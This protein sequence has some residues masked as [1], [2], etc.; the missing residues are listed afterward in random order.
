MLLK[1]CPVKIYQ[2]ILF[3]SAL[4]VTL[5]APFSCR[6]EIDS[7]VTRSGSHFYADSQPFYYTGTNNFYLS[8]FAGDESYRPMVD[9]VLSSAKS[10]GLSVIRT[11]AFNDGGANRDGYPVS[12]AYQTA[13]G[14]YNENAFKGLDYVLYK[15]ESY[16][17]RVLPT[18]V[19]NWDDY[20]G[21][22]WYN[23]FSPSAASHDDFYTDP[24]TRQW[25]K[26][27]VT[28]V[29]NRTN[30]YNGR[31]YKDDPTIMA[32]EL[33]NEAR[34][35]SDPT[36]AKLRNWLDEM[37]S[38]VKANDANHLVTTG[39]EGF[40]KDRGSQWYQNGSTGGDFVGDHNLANIDFA[41]LH[42]YSDFWNWDME[43]ALA[44]IEQHISDADILNKPLIFEEFGKQLP[45]DVRD[46]WY[47]AY[48]TAVYEAAARGSSMAGSNFWMLEADASG[49]ND[50]FGVSYPADA[51]TIGIIMSNAEAMNGLV[52]EPP[53][54][55]LFLASLLSLCYNLRR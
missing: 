21:M 16:G 30:T 14:V 27:Y 35:E 10:M 52:P 25:Y 47:R 42:V 38:Y 51:S 15:A 50:G 8:Y 32:W 11:W 17:I 3:Y 28:T 44:W 48:L 39:V 7:F 9:Q 4:I 33:A 24:A 46:T 19:N 5:I 41:T 18:L 20:G 55:F 6:A 26:D 1:K 31:V 53:T 2:S 40:Y 54:V 45:A 12:W 49:H 37:S 13:P 23:S 36:G 22:N 34:A 29:M 43:Q